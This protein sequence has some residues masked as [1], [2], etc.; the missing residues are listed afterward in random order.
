MTRRDREA[1]ELHEAVARFMRALVRR[2]AA[3]D[4][5]AVTALA[6]I[7]N[8][9]PTALANGVRA[10]RGWQPAHGH[11]PSWTDVARLMGMSRQAAQQRW[12]RE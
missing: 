4:E 10:W 5:Y 6:A 12:G 1:H 9:A 11:S 7:A 3:G 2:A 8:D